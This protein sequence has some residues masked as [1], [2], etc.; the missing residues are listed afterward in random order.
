MIAAAAMHRRQLTLNERWRQVD[1]PPFGLGIGVTTGDVAAGLLGSEE[2]SEFTVVGDT[3]NL[4]AR[5][6]QLAVAGETVLSDVTYATVDDQIEAQPL[7][8]PTRT[9][10]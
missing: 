1:L 8:R 9:A 6:Q 10:D 5:L 2:R 3:V 7:E 4:A